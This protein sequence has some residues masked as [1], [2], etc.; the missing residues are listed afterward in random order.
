M[1]AGPKPGRYE[2]PSTYST[3]SIVSHH[4][5][6]SHTPNNSRRVPKSELATTR[7]KVIDLS[8]L[9]EIAAGANAKLGH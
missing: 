4:K 3:Q 2:N 1:K 9:Q 7:L 6:S 5:H 8:L